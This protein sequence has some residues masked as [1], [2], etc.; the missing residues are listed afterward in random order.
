MAQIHLD[1]ESKHA[2]VIG[3]LPAQQQPFV[4]HAELSR[5]AF[6]RHYQ[7]LTKDNFPGEVRRVCQSA[8]M[9]ESPEGAGTLGSSKEVGG[10]GHGKVFQQPPLVHQTMS[11]QR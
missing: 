2:E 7:L 1:A 11:M 9:V 5:A 8:S 10:G 4:E 3:M 6:L